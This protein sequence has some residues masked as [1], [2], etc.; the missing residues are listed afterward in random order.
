MHS[1]PKCYPP[2]FRKR[3]VWTLWQQWHSP[4]DMFQSVLITDSPPNLCWRRERQQEN[5]CFLL[6]L[7]TGISLKQRAQH[8]SVLGLPLSVCGLCEG[9]TWASST[10][11]R[12]KRWTILYGCHHSFFRAKPMNTFAFIDLKNTRSDFTVLHFEKYISN[13]TFICVLVSWNLQPG[14]KLEIE[15]QQRRSRV[16]WSAGAAALRGTGGEKGGM[17]RSEQRKKNAWNEGW[18]EPGR[19]VQKQHV[20][21][22]LGKIAEIAWGHVFVLSLTQITCYWLAYNY[23]CS[24]RHVFSLQLLC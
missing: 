9:E 11:V 7:F 3:Q 18:A 12:R 6:I 4:P 2:A 16:S 5:W 20:Q 15:F 23:S 10:P 17:Y 24:F 1:Q 22:T 14:R 21:W 13:S 8:S 19:S